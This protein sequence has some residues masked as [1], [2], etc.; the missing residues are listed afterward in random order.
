MLVD[1]G[2]CAFQEVVVVVCGVWCVVCEGGYSWSLVLTAL[3]FFFFFGRWEILLAAQT[4]QWLWL[5]RRNYGDGNAC[6]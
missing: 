1:Y 6:S 3:S 5:T 4:Q 2:D